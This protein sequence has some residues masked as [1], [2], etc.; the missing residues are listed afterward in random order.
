MAK[1][2]EEYGDPVANG[3]KGAA[4]S[5]EVRRKRREFRPILQELLALPYDKN[6]DQNNYYALMVSLFK[7]AEKGDIKALELIMKIVKQMPSDTVELVTNKLNI[8]IESSSKEGDD[9]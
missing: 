8:N 1:F 3:K 4:K 2:G 7:K 5:V 9:A 6:P